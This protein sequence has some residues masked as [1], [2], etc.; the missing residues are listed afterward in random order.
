M[1]RRRGPVVAL[2]AVGLLLGTVSA[3]ALDLGRWPAGSLTAVNRPA[4]P[5]LS[6]SAAEPGQRV[7][8]KGRLPSTVARSV[9][10]QRQ[11]PAKAWRRVTAAR[12]DDRGRYR[13]R[14]TA[15]SATT[16]YRVKAPALVRAERRYKQLVTRVALLRV[17]S[18]P[19]PTPSPSPTPRPAVRLA[20]PAS[21][22]AAGPALRAEV[23]VSPVATGTA[24]V[25]RRSG[26]EWYDAGSAPVAADGTAVVAVALDDLGVG[27]IELRAVAGGVASETSQVQVTPPAVVTAPG[28][29]DTLVGPFTA[30]V[31]VDPAL[32]PTAVRLFVDG[33]SVPDPA[34]RAGDGTWRVDV[35]PAAL[36]VTHRHVD[37]VAQ[38]RTADGRGLSTPVSLHLRPSAGGLPPGFRSD[39][40]VAG[41]DLPTSFAAI[42]EHRVLVAEKS[43]L[44]RL[45]VDGAL[46]PTPVLDLRAVVFDRADSGLIDVALD[47]GFA[48]NGWFY[49]AY[50]RDDDSQ[51]VWSTQRVER[52]TLTGET[53]APASVHV[54]LGAPSLG[55]CQAD[56]TTPGCLVI[57]DRLH[58]V[59]DLL[60]MPDGSL[61]VAVGDG[62]GGDPI[63][64]V[65]A[66]RLDVLAGKVLRVDPGTGLGLPDN[67][68]Y[69]PGTPASNRGR[70]YAYGLRNP[71]RLALAPDGDVYA[72]DVGEVA[73]EE[74]DRLLPGGNYGWPCFEGPDPGFAIPGDPDCI[75]VRSGSVTH[76]LPVVAYRH[77]DFM[78]AVT[79]GPFYD[80]DVYP[81]A[82]QGRMFLGDYTMGR[83]W[84]L[85]PDQ[86]S[87]RLEDFGVPPALGAGVEYAVGP[88]ETIWYADVASGRVRSI[89]YDPDQTSCP[90]GDFLSETF[91]NRLFEPEADGE[92]WVTSCVGTPPT[93]P[94]LVAPGSP[95]HGSGWSMR[96]SGTPQLAPGTYELDAASSGHLEVRVDAE[97]VPDGGTFTVAGADLNEGTADIEVRLTNNPDF[98]DNPYFRDFDWGYRL[99][100][101]RVGTAPVVT[102]DGPSAGGRV[103]PGDEVAWTVSATDA[104][105]GALDPSAT[106]VTVEVLHYGTGSPHAH[107]S[108]SYAGPTGST[109]VEDLHAPG[110]IVYRLTGVATDSSGWVS[111]SPPVYV[112]L[113]GN[114]AGPCS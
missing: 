41:L 81:A 104:E 65:V 7:R 15:P 50:V 42:D 88:D 19:T 100:W 53:A 23:R 110:R 5:N 70:V 37:L 83:I 10:L 95:N 92:P 52:Y 114:A 75:A 6:P 63:R 101:T 76:R 8:V 2:L 67:P 55:T 21:A 14:L 64:A 48:S 40:V 91:R 61:L 30:E 31:A 22:V 46:R 20:V 89:V 112:C 74:V 56:A 96:W 113:T 49:V 18:T 80:G 99:S 62:A 32:S 26:S 33:F 38:V 71:F 28:P 45:A 4:A 109:E 24:T 51:S 59:D 68:Y 47:P 54:V 34:I 27:R 43:G 94:D 69:E 86:A 25:Q 106:R 82:Y 44:V 93:G 98:D 84:T 35:D 73:W 85:D 11:T 1:S 87:P 29:G 90:S 77:Q 39:T 66:Q 102:V 78:G 97:V 16:R 72:G 9:V 79:L 107:P 111:E 13:F 58:T 57:K 105:D 3:A 103:R 17:G 36:G 60:F 108:G 12:T